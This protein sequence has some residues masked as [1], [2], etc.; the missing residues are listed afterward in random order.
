MRGILIS[1]FF[2]AGCSKSPQMG[3]RIEKSRVDSVWT[4]GPGE[5]NSLQVD[6]IYF[7]RTS[8]GR[9]HQSRLPVRI[10]DSC[11]YIFH[12]NKMK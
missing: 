7:F 8:E 3:R 4:K 10:G 2:L 6:P 5:I 12:L 1:I 11:V 9:I